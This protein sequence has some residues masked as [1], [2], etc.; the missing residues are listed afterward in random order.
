[1]L[2]KAA[3]DHVAAKTPYGRVVQTMDIGLSEPWEYCEPKAYLRYMSSLSDSYAEVMGSIDGPT[4]FSV[5]LYLDEICPGNPFRP[6]KARKLWGLYWACV[7]WPSWLLA[8]SGFWPVLGLIKSSTLNNFPGGE[9]AFWKYIMRL[10]KNDI[11]IQ[12]VYREERVPVTLS[13]IGTLADEAALKAVTDF[14]GASGIKICMD[15][16]MH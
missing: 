6:D 5:V 7:Q 9:G 14:K 13:Y 1:M 4:K 3:N 11:H 8:R 15:T 2:R 12:L 10:F 16:L